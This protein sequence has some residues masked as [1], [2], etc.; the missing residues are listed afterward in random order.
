MA[1]QKYVAYYYDSSN[2]VAL[3][4]VQEINLSIGRQRQLD[5]ITASTGS[6]VMRYPNGYASPNTYL[7]PGRIILIQNETSTPYYVWTGKISNVQVE[8]GISYKS[9]VGNADYMTISLESNFATLG[10]MQGN[11]YAI[12]SARVSTQ[13]DTYAAAQTG[14]LTAYFG[15][16]LG[17]GSPVLDAYT[18]STT[19]ADYIAN[20]CLTLNARIVEGAI[21]NQTAVVSPFGYGQN[22]DTTPTISFSDTTNNATNQ[23][24]N[25]INFSSFSDNYYTQVTVDPVSYAAQTSTDPTA[26]APYRTYQVNTI[27]SSTGQAVDYANYLLANYSTKNAKIASF[28]CSGEAQ[29]TFGLDQIGAPAGIA[30]GGYNKFAPTVG[31]RVSVTFRGTTYYCVV[32][33]V[34]MNATP[35]GS[36]FTFYVSG[37]DLN[38]YLILN[39]TVFGTLNDNRLGY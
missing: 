37:Q 35:A 1:I 26:S 16:G 18:V 4:N 11:N 9:S 27:N 29:N 23:V 28:S 10:R 14:T 32:E 5:Q 25:Q 15:P 24:Y 17:I 31:M 19:W 21:Y 6:I 30:L 33:G 7:T 8:Y 39:N 20:V 38:N 13:V 12:P 22:I 34:T 36:V 3:S 2:Y